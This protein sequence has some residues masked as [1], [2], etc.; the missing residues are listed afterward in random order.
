MECCPHSPIRL[1][2]P[3]A[4][5]V[6]AMTFTAL[7]R[8]L[9]HLLSCHSAS[10][11]SCPF[12]SEHFKWLFQTHQLLFSLIKTLTTLWALCTNLTLKREL[13]AP[14]W[15]QMWSELFPVILASLQRWWEFHTCSQGS[16][17][18]YRILY[19]DCLSSRMNHQLTSW[20]LAESKGYFY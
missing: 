13:R 7:G 11:T 2:S 17:V 18:K 3:T 15:H 19:S 20:L 10:T 8:H 1:L 16:S 9:N 4:V 6:L 5:L 14:D 12:S